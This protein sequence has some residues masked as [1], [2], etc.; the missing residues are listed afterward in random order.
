MKIIVPAAEGE[1]TGS[2][3]YYESKRGSYKDMMSYKKPTELR[4]L[5][6]EYPPDKKIDKTEFA[7]HILS[8]VFNY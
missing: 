1:F 4:K 8:F 2:K 6:L 7:K 5:K 3:W